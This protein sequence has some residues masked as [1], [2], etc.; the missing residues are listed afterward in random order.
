M[1]VLKACLSYFQLVGLGKLKPNTVV[2]GYKA[3][4]RK[5]DPVELKAYFNTLQ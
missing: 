3:N 1:K 2:L 5:C 4:W